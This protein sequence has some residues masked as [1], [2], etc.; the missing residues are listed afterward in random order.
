MLLS[1]PRHA[2]NV[3]IPCKCSFSGRGAVLRAPAVLR[4]SRRAVDYDAAQASSDEDTDD[5]RWQGHESHSE[6][7]TSSAQSSAAA[8]PAQHSRQSGHDLSQESMP[9]EWHRTGAHGAALSDISRHD[10]M[11]ADSGV[12]NRASLSSR[13]GPRPSSAHAPIAAHSLQEHTISDH[14]VAVSTGIGQAV[15]SASALADV[16]APA[17][18]DL[19]PS[20]HINQ[21]SPLLAAYFPFG[22][23]IAAVRMA[24]WVVLLAVDSPLLTDNNFMINVLYGIL[25]IRV[26]WR[27]TE[28]L[29]EGRHVVVSN[30]VTVGDLMVLYARP[31]PYVHLITSRLPRRITQAQHHRVKLRHASGE[32]YCGLADSAANPDS[33]HLFPE[34]GMTNGRGMMKFSR[35]FMRFGRGLPIV[36]AAMRADN[37]FSISTH[38]L[39]SSF[40]ANMF[41]FCFAPWMSLD[42]TVL[43]PME[44]AEGEGNGK[45]VERVQQAI[46]KELS[47]PISD[48]TLKEKHKTHR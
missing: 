11:A 1:S 47:I 16:A 20:S 23:A 21:W 48:M 9:A 45:F 32:T 12:R 40:V 2:A 35:G 31:Q 27:G 25:G 38:T 33:V 7:T 22:C 3:F 39:S 17:A 15:G 43:P 44:P 13:S 19:F 26:Q 8:V 34:G 36:P 41:W 14:A 30:H 10:N 18:A 4:S 42:V 24:M 29:P 37:P 46:A 6:R 5:T 28:N